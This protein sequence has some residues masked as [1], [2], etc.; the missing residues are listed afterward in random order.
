ML[1]RL[2]HRLSSSDRRSAWLAFLTH[3]LSN[4]CFVMEPSTLEAEQP[5]RQLDHAAATD[6]RQEPHDAEAD[7]LR[8]PLAALEMELHRVE[9]LCWLHDG[10]ITARIT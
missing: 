4:F 5:Q 6:E 7:N 9:Q 1:R 8:D 2:L 3:L 10:L